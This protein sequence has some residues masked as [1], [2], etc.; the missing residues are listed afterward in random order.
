MENSWLPDYIPKGLCTPA[1]PSSHLKHTVKTQSW[2]KCPSRALGCCCVNWSCMLALMMENPHVRVDCSSP[3]AR[4]PVEAMSYFQP[5]SR[6]V[7]SDDHL[8]TPFVGLINYINT[9]KEPHLTSECIKVLFKWCLLCVRLREGT[10]WEQTRSIFT[11]WNQ[12]RRW[13]YQLVNQWALGIWR[14]SPSYSGCRV[15]KLIVQ[16]LSFFI[17]E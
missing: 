6:A 4:G 16:S 5:P 10:G 2:G 13:I 1:P 11:I 12:V 17:Q 9:F 8:W 15:Q 7:K 3:N 14:Q